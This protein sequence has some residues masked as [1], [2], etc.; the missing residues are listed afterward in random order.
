VFYLKFIE[1]NL[2]KSSHGRSGRIWW[3]GF[4]VP[5]FALFSIQFGG[6]VGE[7]QRREL[8]TDFWRNKSLT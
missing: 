6:E 5:D 1:V 8:P 2:S 4:S 7:F 3:I